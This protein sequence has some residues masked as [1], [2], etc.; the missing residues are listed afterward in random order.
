[1]GIWGRMRGRDKVWMIDEIED[2]EICLI[3]DSDICPVTVQKPENP[4]LMRVL[5]LLLCLVTNK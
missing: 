3:E 2:G 5:R 1:M 4:V